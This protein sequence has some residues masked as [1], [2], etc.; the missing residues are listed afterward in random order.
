MTD[1]QDTR[2]RP[3]TSLRHDAAPPAPSSPAARTTT[4]HG[5]QERR[6]HAPLRAVL[7]AAFC[8]ACLLFSLAASAAET[9]RATAAAAQSQLGVALNKKYADELLWY[10]YKAAAVTKT[11]EV[12]MAVVAS[13]PPGEPSKSYSL[14]LWLIDAAGERKSET[15]IRRPGEAA[16]MTVPLRQ[17]EPDVTALVVLDNG[18][19]L[20]VVEFFP[21]R[22]VLVR[23]DRTGKQ[24]LTQEILSP[25]RR[26]SLTKLIP[27]TDGQFILA[28]HESFDAL[29]VKVDATGKVVWEKLEDRGRM[30]LFVDGVATE[31]GGAL[32]VGNSGAYDTLGA[33]PSILWVGRYSPTGALVKEVSVAGRYGSIAHARDEGFVLVYDKSVATTQDIRAQRYGADWKKTWETPIITVEGG[34][35]QFQIAPAPD[36]GFIVAGAKYLLPFVAKL[37]AGGALANAFWGHTLEQAVVYD[38]VAAPGEYYVASS[39]YAKNQLNKMVSQV[40]LLKLSER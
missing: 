15:H 24:T 4:P 9:P 17:Q 18:D 6:P 20:L 21:S 37:G 7:L 29:A 30:D 10:Q 11:R 23:V 19:A 25:A 12:L 38:L 1:L 22:P 14:R 13:S 33:G 34:V 39:V 26:A 16:N 32:L 8:C 5:G 28:G 36:G 35:T 27:T 2:P 31:N 40:R 3:H